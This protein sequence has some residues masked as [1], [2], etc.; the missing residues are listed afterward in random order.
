MNL[1]ERQ[2]REA[3]SEFQVNPPNHC[4]ERIQ[5]TLYTQ[6]K[7]SPPHLTEKS[8][9]IPWKK[10]KYL[11]IAGV[12]LILLL[13]FPFLIFQWN[14][15]HQK[16]PITN[17]KN[18]S[19]PNSSYQNITKT[20]PNFNTASIQLQHNH[21]QQNSRKVLKNGIKKEKV[22]LHS[23]NP[24]LLTQKQQKEDYQISSMSTLSLLNLSN[25]DDLKQKTLH[26]SSLTSVI[27]PL[28]NKISPSSPPPTAH[29]T[30][31]NVTNSKRNKVL[32]TIHKKRKKIKQIT[33]HLKNKNILLAATN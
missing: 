27:P 28:P 31:L 8:P 23:Q 11:L 25:L 9:F 21:L 15:N 18:I 30:R 7:T 33:L 13:L 6:Q 24:S 2:I 5:S 20:E 16:N 14:P 10:Q 12:F 1:F 17:Q 4:W 29:V 19:S 22:N 3:F 26:S 32:I